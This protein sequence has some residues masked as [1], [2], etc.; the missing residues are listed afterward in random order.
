MSCLFAS[1][2]HSNH[3]VSRSPV[4]TISRSRQDEAAGGPNS[5]ASAAASDEM[6]LISPALS[7]PISL[8]KELSLTDAAVFRLPRCIS[9]VYVRPSPFLNALVVP[10]GLHLRIVPRASL[11]DFFF[12]SAADPDAVTASSL[13]F[14]ISSAL[15]AVARPFPAH[16]VQQADLSL[17]PHCPQSTARPPGASSSSST[18]TS[19]P[20][21]PATS[22][23]SAPA[24]TASV[25]RPCPLLRTTSEAAKLTSACASPA[26]QATP[27]RA[28]TASSP[29][30][31]SRAVT[32]P[33][34]TEPAASRSTAP[35]SPTR[36][37]VPAFCRDVLVCG[38]LTLSP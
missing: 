16:Q 26:R 12:C 34:T 25:R 1:C 7:C 19:S 35:S 3:V 17:T 15:P 30:S 20:R 31:C 8:Y 9:N 32:S 38:R 36:T 28:S 14:D 22:A 18:T 37:W 4:P 24:R 29:S 13:Q 23:S 5:F 6:A 21:R 27:A 10:K 11:A 33:T 2:R